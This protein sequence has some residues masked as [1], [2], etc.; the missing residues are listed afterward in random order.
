MDPDENS[1]SDFSGSALGRVS[2]RS[3]QC[4]R[5]SMRASS[6]SN[7]SSNINIDDLSLLSESFPARLWHRWMGLVGAGDGVTLL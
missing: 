4:S 5:M 7:S 2:R 6:A 3:S 1:I